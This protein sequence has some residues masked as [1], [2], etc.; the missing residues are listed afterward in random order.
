MANEYITNESGDNG[1]GAPLRVTIPPFTL[2]ISPTF[3]SFSSVQEDLL[4]D[5]ANVVLEEYLS[6]QVPDGISLDY[7]S[8]I[9]VV[10]DNSIRRRQLQETATVLEIAGGLASFFRAGGDEAPPPTVEEVNKW[11][12][13]ALEGSLLETLQSETDLNYVETIIFTSLSPAPTLSP[14]SLGGIQ[15]G[16]QIKAS[17]SGKIAAGVV[18]ALAI[19]GV[20]AAALLL[21]RRR[22]QSS[23][24]VATKSSPIAAP[25]GVED[26]DDDD[27]SEDAEESMQTNQNHRSFAIS[28]VE[29]ESEWTLNSNA[30]DAFT[31]KSG[32]KVFP[33]SSH[34]MLQTESFER[35]RQ[36][37]LKK[38][39]MQA[40]WSTATP[41]TN[42]QKG[43]GTV[44]QPSHFSAAG[45]VDS[46]DM[47]EHWNPDDTETASSV[48]QDS[49]F[50]FEAQGEEVVL[51]PPSRTRSSRQDLV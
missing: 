40:P 42:V 3:G 48:N 4:E 30:T 41:A 36:V 45:R 32:G 8:L 2:T 26:D 33:R 28:E 9:N 50:L 16:T 49:P 19:A 11:V 39:M 23:S 46:Y 15:D 7:V 51:M 37:S 38:D 21:A 27:S 34:S 17:D 5:T 18:G 14:L 35:D 10:Q 20:L 6:T 44:L 47:D 24:A 29:S 12:S 13:D 31:V 1:G 25:V 22:K 43:S